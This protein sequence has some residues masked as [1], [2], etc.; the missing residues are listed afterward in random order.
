MI[1]P[2]L[3]LTTTLLVA[4]VAIHAAEKQQTKLQPSTDRH[5]SNVTQLTFEG[6]NGEAYFSNDGQQLIYQSNRGGYACDK[7]WTMNI[8]GSNKQRVSPDHGAH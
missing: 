3:L 5:M 1:N 6:D 8:D 4:S 7:I 2:K